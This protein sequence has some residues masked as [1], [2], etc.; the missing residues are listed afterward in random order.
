[1]TVA[2]A[3]K[4]LKQHYHDASEIFYLYVLDRDGRLIGVVNLRALILAESTQTIEEIMS[5]DVITI[6]VDTTVNAYVTAEIIA[7]NSSRPILWRS[8]P[9][10]PWSTTSRLSARAARPVR[11]TLMTL[12]TTL[13]S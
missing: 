7:S 1:M 11:V 4:F 9:S 10:G 2:G 13:G 12:L 8:T 3:I 5:R 6:T